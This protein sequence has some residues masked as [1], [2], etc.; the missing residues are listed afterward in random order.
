MERTMPELDWFSYACLA[1]L[2]NGLQGFRHKTVA[3]QDNDPYL[4]TFVSASVSFLI[5]GGLLFQ[6]I[7]DFSNLVYFCILTVIGAAGFILITV[8]K[9]RALSLLPSGTVFTI[10]RSNAV[11]VLA[12]TYVFSELFPTQITPPQMAGVLLILFGIAALYP[13][14]QLEPGRGS[15]SDIFRGLGLIFLAAAI[16]ALLY[17]SQ[18]LAIEDLGITKNL[19]IFA[20]NLLVAIFA[21]SVIAGKVIGGATGPHRCWPTIQ[22]GFFGGLYGYLAFWCFLQSINE[23]YVALTVSINSASFIIPILLSAYFYHEKLTRRT[24]FA[25]LLT[26]V[27]V[28]S[29]GVLSIR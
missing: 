5:A 19:F 6:E 15:Q 10:F 8:A 9:L 17:I 2:F 29:I 14:H 22:N 18:K 7:P 28:I 21:L 23:G 25:V 1:S 12:I 20:I 27:G 13:R 24:I 4:F 3:H 16:A 11:F 26:F